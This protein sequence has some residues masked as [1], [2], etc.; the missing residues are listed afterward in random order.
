MVIRETIDQIPIYTGQLL[1]KS[2][3]KL[4]EAKYRSKIIQ[5][6]TKAR[7]TMWEDCVFEAACREVGTDW[8]FQELLDNDEYLLAADELVAGLELMAKVG[9]RLHPERNE[10][11]FYKMILEIYR[12]ILDRKDEQ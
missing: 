11:S 7:A 6:L 3:P 2:G 12:L 4:S 8:K 9:L 10:I 5:L 1:A